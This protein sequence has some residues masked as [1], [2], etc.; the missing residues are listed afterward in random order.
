[1]AQ[2]KLLDFWASVPAM[3]VRIAL[4][5]K[6]IEYETQEEDL[7]NKSPLLLE[8]NPVQKKIP[9]LI[10]NGKPICESMIIVEY[11]D[12]VWNDKSPLLP[13]DAH[14]RA[15]ARFWVNFI[16][17]KIADPMRR[18]VWTPRSEN[19]EAAANDLVEIFKVMEAELGDKPYFDGDSFGFVDV[20][21]VPFY[22]CFYTYETFGNFIIARECPRLVA[23]VRKCLQKESVSKTL[24]DPYKVYEG[25]LEYRKK[26]GLE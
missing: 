26:L 12:E 3:R 2:V 18:L 13:S 10:H 17:K 5:E 20:A 9:V 19:K 11:I 23:W 6:G 16:D 24:P 22:S 15:R 14:E 8:M 21:L 25:L 1:M 4:A 7:R